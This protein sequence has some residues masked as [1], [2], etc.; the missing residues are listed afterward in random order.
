MKHLDGQLAQ[1]HAVDRDAES[2]AH[3]V[4]PLVRLS[5]DGHEA[6]SDGDGLS[7]LDEARY[8][9][10]RFEP[11]TDGDGLGDG[12]EYRTSSTDPLKRCSLGSEKFTK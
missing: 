3:G 8:G 5:L 1:R 6:D 12:Y 10:K 4:H 7:D 2:F 9:T 11:D